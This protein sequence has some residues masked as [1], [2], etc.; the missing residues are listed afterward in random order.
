MQA[1]NC[2]EVTIKKPGECTAA[3]FQGFIPFVLAG[4][5]V[6]TARLDERVRKAEFLR[7]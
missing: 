5:E 7:V 1:T 4:G 3:E 2:P 6:M